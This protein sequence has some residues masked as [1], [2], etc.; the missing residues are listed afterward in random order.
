MEIELSGLTRLPWLVR[1][2]E[3]LSQRLRWLND[4]E[5]ISGQMNINK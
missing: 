4:L 1:M 2:G 3:M 5:I